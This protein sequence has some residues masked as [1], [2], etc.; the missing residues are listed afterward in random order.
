MGTTYGPQGL[1]GV[2]GLVLLI[3]VLVWL[4]GGGIGRF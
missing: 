2:L 3:I 1:G 4:F